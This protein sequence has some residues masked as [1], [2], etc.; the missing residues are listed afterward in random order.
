MEEAPGQGQAASGPDGEADDAA[1]WTLDQRMW[2]TGS[3]IGFACSAQ[4]FCQE[5]DESEGVSWVVSAPSIDEAQEVYDIF[6]AD[7]DDDKATD[8][9]LLFP[10]SEAHD[11]LP[12]WA[13]DAVAV[14]VPGHEAGKLAARK[15][16]MITEGTDP[17]ALL[18][19][20]SSI[21]VVARP[22]P[23][24][25]TLR[26][27]SFLVRATFDKAFGESI[28]D[29]VLRRPGQH[30]RLWASASG[31][32]QADVIDSYGFKRVGSRLCG[33]LRVRTRDAAARLWRASG[34]RANN[35]HWFI[36]LVGD[37]RDLPCAQDVGVQWV[38]WTS[39]ETY[40]DYIAR[41]AARTGLGLVLG[42][43]IGV[44]MKRTDPSF[45]RPS[46][47]WRMRNIP[48]HFMMSDVTELGEATGFQDVV[49]STRRRTRRGHDWC[50]RAAR[51]DALQIVS[52][53]VQW[54]PADP[55]TSEVVVL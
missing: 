18:S 8:L 36:D 43:G 19:R 9:T 5:L 35:A 3:A 48:S 32:T 16:W 37:A 47:M 50:F 27:S 28:W 44:R 33:M 26:A 40:S 49:M 6:L 12:D 34:R 21:H 10:V 13:A 1:M 30:A 53:S 14:A 45:Q 39:D 23:T 25:Q 29:E 41:A 20:A 46:V 31:V 4:D 24:L 11:D 17:P 7:K 52:Q 2:C 15:C 38:A 42:R 55:G 22:P 54:D 51:G